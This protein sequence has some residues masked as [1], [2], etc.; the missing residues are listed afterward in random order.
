MT[1]WSPPRGCVRTTWASTL[2]PRS[3]PLVRIT[4]VPTERPRLERGGSASRPPQVETLTI[5]VDDRHPRALERTVLITFG[6]NHSDEDLEVLRV[7]GDRIGRDR[8][9]KRPD[10]FSVAESFDPAAEIRVVVAASRAAVPRPPYE[11]QLAA[12]AVPPDL[13]GGDAVA[14]RH[15]VLAAREPHARRGR[16]GRIGGRRFRGRRAARL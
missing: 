6:R 8:H 16:V 11:R 1:A 10:R 4:A 14:F 9:V 2:S 3:R 5:V 15:D 12:R 7:F 13:D